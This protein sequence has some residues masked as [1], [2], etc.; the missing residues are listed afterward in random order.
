MNIRK[1]A[2][3]Y[4]LKWSNRL[5]KLLPRFERDLLVLSNRTINNS[6]VAFDDKINALDNI[7]TE[8]ENPK[9][10]EGLFR[11]YANFQLFSRMTDS[12]E[13]MYKKDL[14]ISETMRDI[15]QEYALARPINPENDEAAK[16]LVLTF[17]KLSDIPV[18]LA[19]EDGERNL[20]L[21]SYV[22]LMKPYDAED[23]TK[24]T[25]FLAVSEKYGILVQAYNH[26][27]SN[28]F[29]LAVEVLDRTLRALVLLE[30]PDDAL[31]VVETAFK[32]NKKLEPVQLLELGKLLSPSK[33]R[34]LASFIDIKGYK[35]PG[36]R[37]IQFTLRH[38]KEDDLTTS[39]AFKA[40]KQLEAIPSHSTAETYSI[41]LDALAS[42]GD[43]K[44]VEQLWKEMLNKRL[45]PPIEAYHSL[46]EAYSSAGDNQSVINVWNSA[47]CKLPN[48][49]AR[50]IGT[51]LRSCATNGS[52]EVLK[53]QW[54]K[55]KMYDY[56]LDTT[57]YG[58]Y[59]E[60][61][62]KF[63]QYEEAVDVFVKDLCR[64]SILKPESNFRDR[65]VE[66]LE[67]CN[68]PAEKKSMLQALVRAAF[69]GFRKVKLSPKF[70]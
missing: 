59:V 27:K 50:I 57:V 21:E 42:K 28:N 16:K 2:K 69:D 1:I 67:S 18:P 17:K 64:Y 60:G 38:Q 43:I 4:G 33:K 41:L 24:L 49:S 39:E 35:Q 54:E 70:Q 8:F 15:M 51:L 30:R 52:L 13:E 48:N 66:V 34:T 22:Q 20:T 63:G 46:M 53:D 26:M 12:L 45:L 7:R 19:K 11:V 61:L 3:W 68:A 56:R 65:L 5:E 32:L 6:Q 62:I 44:A 55:V 40:I 25:G 10:Y 37:L 23:W 14:P 29:P 58:I 9:Y 36:S 31:E 47:Y